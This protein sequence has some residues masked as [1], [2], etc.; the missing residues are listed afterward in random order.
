MSVLQ[1]LLNDREIRTDLHPATL[2][3]DFLR[4]VEELKGT[5]EGCREGD[6]GA[7]VV[8]IGD[9]SSE[10]LRYRPVTSCLVPIGSL[11][12]KHLVTIEGLNVQ[13]L[14]PVQE[15]IV[16]EGASQCGFCTPGIV[17]SLTGAI[18]DHGG[19]LAVEQ[20]KDALGGHLC[21]CTGYRSLK[22][23]NR[24]IGERLGAA[25]GLHELM[26]RG[27]IPLYFKS[28]EDRL[29]ALVPPVSVNG[30]THSEYRIAGGTDLYV[31]RGDELPHTSVDV[32]DADPRLEGIFDGREYVD[33]GA[34]TT[35]EDFARS[36]TVRAILP[37]IR[38]YMSL[39]ASLQIRTRATL[40]GNVINASPIGDMTI[41][42]LALESDLVLRGREGERRVAMTSF[43]K[44]YKQMDIRPGEVLT[45]IL[46]PR[47]RSGT[48]IGWEKV[49]KR[50]TLDIATVNFAAAMTASD[51]RIEHASVAVGGVAPVPLHLSETSRLLSGAELTPQTVAEA[52]GVLDDEIAPI[53]DIRGSADYK[54]LLAR[55]LLIASLTTLYPEEIPVEAFV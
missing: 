6:C 46:I 41:L 50:R 3:L 27:A 30:E 24:I 32:I 9:L 1:F 37:D 55:R 17:V 4:D 28:I 39:I 8:L 26:E 49:S 13:G 35:F 2:V 36:E 14:S 51:G 43:Y 18:M 23:S 34:A 25:R 45:R 20:V 12:G 10:G 5:K 29:R 33:V 47:P 21:R 48:R 15:A 44:G 22:A 7:C 38:Y 31:E 54:R 52:A 16:E 40:G 53:S 11:L 42:L 19:N